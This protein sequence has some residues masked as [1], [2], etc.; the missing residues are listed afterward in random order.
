MLRGIDKHL[1]V[2][3]SLVFVLVLGIFANVVYG[4][5]AGNIALE[6]RSRLQTLSDALIASVE[7]IGDSDDATEENETWIPNGFRAHGLEGNELKLDNV[8][9]EWFDSERRKLS[10][11]GVCHISMPLNTSAVFEQQDSPHVLLLTR[12]VE[13]GGGLTGYVR[14][15]LSL[16]NSDSYKQKLMSGLILG[17]CIS[18]I[19]SGAAVLW[20]NRLA[21]KPVES[22]MKKLAQF[23]A[24]VSHE[25]KNPIMAIKTN[26][27]VALKHQE[28]M[29][30][31]DRVK[32]VAMVDAANQMQR[33]I[34]DLL[35]MAESEQPLRASELVV[36]NIDQ[37][38]KEVT[39]DLRGLAE[40]RKVS[41]KFVS[42]PTNLKFRG[43]EEDLKRAL[44]NVVQN[45]VQYSKGGGAVS[46]VASRI[47]RRIQFAVV[48]AG[49]GISEEDLP[50]VFDRFWRSDK[51]A[52]YRS[53]GNGLGLSIAQ[54]IVTRYKGDIAVSSEFGEGT[55]VTIALPDSH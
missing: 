2:S 40:S 31:S 32:F 52:S 8:T 1:L 20:F 29:R 38:L 41:L 19:A 25:L 47:G 55:T 33:T 14:L 17:V 51:A 12:P 44:L 7:P 15:G 50:K 36:V 9:V 37:L 22:S 6:N 35:S 27:G 10:E 18:L 53:G 43:R 39:D 11:R 23:T 13:R 49:I 34:A 45:A 3:H 26:G 24:D 46:I 42:K 54:S 4:Y 30:D 28:G 5:A 16:A 21:L 48:D